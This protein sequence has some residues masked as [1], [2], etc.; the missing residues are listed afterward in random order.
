MGLPFERWV[1]QLADLAENETQPQRFLAL[2]LEHILE[3]PWVSG[4]QWEAR[5]G[6]GEFGE[7]SDFFAD[8]SSYNFV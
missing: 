1:Q 5:L 7:K 6:Q 3:L 4:L 2:A 8:L